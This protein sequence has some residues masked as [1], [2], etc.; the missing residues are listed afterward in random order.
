MKNLS[1]IT[2]LLLLLFTATIAIYC[3]TIP[4]KAEPIK[5]FDVNKYLGTWYE[6][7]RYD[8]SFERDLDNVAAQYTINDKGEITVFNSG[9]NYKD[10][11]WQSAT[12]SAKFSSDNNI[13]ALKVSFF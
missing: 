2:K 10:E 11:K 3:S 12:G 8:Y 1:L 5:N 7:A 9:Y 4:Q 13:G 6:I